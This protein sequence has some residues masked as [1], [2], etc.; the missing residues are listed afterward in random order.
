MQR[1]VRDQ[2]CETTSSVSEPLTV[3]YQ[4]SHSP[5]YMPL[6]NM[7]QLNRYS[8]ACVYCYERPPVHIDP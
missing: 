1:P 5:Y 4:Y 2:L 7:R 6:G 3:Q 8:S